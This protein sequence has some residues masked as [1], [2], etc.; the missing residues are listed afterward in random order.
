[1][2]LLGLIPFAGPIILLVFTLL[3]PDPA[4][5]RFDQPAAY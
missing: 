4:G 5:Q 1:M 2:I 3:G